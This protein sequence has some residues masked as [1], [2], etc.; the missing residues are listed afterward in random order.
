MGSVTALNPY[1]LAQEINAYVSG[2]IQQSYIQDGS[3]VVVGDPIVK[4]VDND[5]QLLDRL[6]AEREQ[7]LAQISAAEA[8]A[9]TARIDANRTKELFNEG[10][11]AKRDYEK[12]KIK[13]QES[14]ARVAEASAKLTRADV[15]LS[16][17]SAQ[18]VRAPRNGVI[19]RVNA[20]GNAS[21]FVKVGDSI[22]TFVPDDVERVVELFIDGR[23]VSL[24]KTGDKVRLQFEGWPVVQ[25]SGWPS[26]A[27]GTYGG[28]VISVDPSA[29]TNGRFRVLVKEDPNDQHPWP[30]DDYVRFGS[31]V[32]GWIQ[33]ETV[34][35]GYELWRLFN[36]FPPDFRD[37]NTA[38]K[39]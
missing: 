34:V 3:H 24:V 37:R 1:D 29:Q 22:A 31:K 11:A 2:R 30:S 16:R 28:I 21:T 33:L 14:L 38:V 13:L 10:L 7:V 12:T 25:F 5:P 35:I 19:L 20:G 6:Q 36:D 39:K 8:V 23:D 32:R 27:V 9:N 18:I 26:V 4:I 17:Q 15:N